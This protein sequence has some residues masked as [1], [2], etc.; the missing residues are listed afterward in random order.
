M[1]ETTTPQTPVTPQ[2]P[3]PVTSQAPAAAKPST[4][5]LAPIN[6]VF[7]DNEGVFKAADLT[8]NSLSAQAPEG[9]TMA[10]A[11]ALTTLSKEQQEAVQ[12][13]QAEGYF[14]NVGGKTFAP[15]KEGIERRQARE[16]LTTAA[17]NGGIET[18]ANA[19]LWDKETN[20]P[21]G[22][23]R[24][25]P[26]TKDNAGL[27]SNDEDDKKAEALLKGYRVEG[28]WWERNKD[29]M[30]PLI[31]ALAGTA[32]GFALSYIFKSK[33]GD[34]ANLANTLIDKSLGN[35][36]TNENQQNQGN[37]NENTNENGNE[38]KNSSSN[39]GNVTQT[40]TTNSSATQSLGGVSQ[41]ITPPPAQEQTG[42]AP[43]SISGLRR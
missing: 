26:A 18:L 37:G 24:V 27:S 34:G 40:P 17:Q 11:T 15:T 21:D 3:A 39:T 12:K 16:A 30:I 9:A 14:I 8:I 5:I 1:T 28:D 32:L 19:G 41:N 4:P 25:H 31:M 10:D 20:R 43:S 35:Q 23:E 22:L 38:N 7:Q 2:E 29:W 13:A 36:N 6:Q 42:R 33:D